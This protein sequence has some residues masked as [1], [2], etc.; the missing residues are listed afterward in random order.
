MSGSSWWEP[1]AGFRYT[2]SSYGSDAFMLGI[3]DGEVWRLQG[4]ARFGTEYYWGS[5]QVLA[6]FTALAYSD[7]AISGL[8]INSGGFGG[9]VVPEEEGLVRF[10]GILGLNFVHAPGTT[11]FINAEVRAGEEYFGVGGNVGLRVSLN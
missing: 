5:T 1:T 2:H 3:T 11:T 4:G 9:A 7:V 8:V 10:Q 6:T